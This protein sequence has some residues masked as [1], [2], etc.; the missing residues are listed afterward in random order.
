MAFLY[1]TFIRKNSKEL[2]EKLE[3]LGYI[4]GAWETPRFHYPYLCTW[5]NRKWGLFKG[6]WIKK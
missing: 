5:T 2:R 3:E 1:K 4:N 6:E